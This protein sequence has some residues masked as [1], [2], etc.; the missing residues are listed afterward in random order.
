MEDNQTKRALLVIDVQQDFI[1]PDGPFKHSHVNAVHII[2]N[3]TAILPHFRDH[4]GIVIW[5]KSD[6]SKLESEPKYLIRPEGEQFAN[7]PLNDE[8]LSGAHKTFPLCVPGTDGEK[9]IPEVDS[10]I[11][12]DQDIIITKTYY[13]AFTD[14]NLADILKDIK[15]V[16][17]CGLMTNV[18]VH[19]TTTDA[20]FHG[21]KIFIWTDC[22]G[23]RNETRH[24]MALNHMKRWYATMIN[25]NEYLQQSQ[26]TTPKPVLYFVNGSI[27]SW[28]VMMALYE[29]DIDFEAKRLKVMSKPKETKSPEFLAINPRG[30]TPTFVDTDGSII[31]ESLAILHYLE[32][33]YPNTLPLIPIE[34]SEHIRVLQLIQESQNLVDIYEP[35]EE[36]VFKTPEHEQSSHKDS[37]AK[38]LKLID[39][40]LAFWEM[41]LTKTSF[42]ACD[43]FT[44]ADCAFYPVI[45]YLIHRGLNIDKYPTLKNYVN[46]IKMKPAAINAHPRGWKERG[47]R[48]NVF[49]VVKNILNSCNN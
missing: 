17:I 23:Y 1:S 14:T 30:L 20:F 36:V 39:E 21:H 13:S 40:E 18:C 28:R 38:T 22:L 43:K 31:A 10:L 34:K 4:N 19:A 8:Y 12:Q 47:G 37:I 7:I 44:L 46:K 32:V 24:R 3:L 35:L 45:A 15:E 5:I 11:K 29:K 33:Y 48:L 2:S 6:Y 25:S 9:F 49:K 42:V 27:P 26:T 41:Y 16:H